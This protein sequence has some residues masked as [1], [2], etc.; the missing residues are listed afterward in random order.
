M[1]GTVLRTLYGIVKVQFTVTTGYTLS[2]VLLFYCTYIITLYYYTVNRRLAC[3]RHI[4]AV[5][6]CFSLFFTVFHCFR[7]ILYKYTRYFL[8][9]LHKGQTQA[10]NIQ[11]IVV[12]DIKLPLYIV[13]LAAWNDSATG[14]ILLPMYCKTR[15]IGV[16]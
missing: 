6:H 9:R 7:R 16:S 1:L 12:M 2:G 3:L 11:D 10:E 4:T 15:E 13:K 8:Y 14:G 5:F